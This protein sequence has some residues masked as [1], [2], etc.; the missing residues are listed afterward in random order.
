[1]SRLLGFALLALASAAAAEPPNGGGF[2][3][4]AG[5]FLEPPAPLSFTRGFQFPRLDYLSPGGWMERQQGILAGVQLWPDTI[6]GVGVLDRKRR[7]S[8][9]AADPQLDKPR[10]GKKVAVGLTFRF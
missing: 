9:S 3:L 6:L 4:P 1:M 8:G 2:Q 7:T 10:R 5:A